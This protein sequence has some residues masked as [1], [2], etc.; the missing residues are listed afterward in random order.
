MYKNYINKSIKDLTTGEIVKIYNCRFEVLKQETPVLTQKGTE[1]FQI[2][3]KY[4][5]EGSY[6]ESIH[7]KNYKTFSGAESRNFNIEQ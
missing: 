3:V 6:P 4:I 5:E 2:K 1:I 7:F